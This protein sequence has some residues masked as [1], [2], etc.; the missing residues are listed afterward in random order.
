[1]K[2]EINFSKHRTYLNLTWYQSRGEDKAQAR[3]KEKSL[4]TVGK[5]QKD[6]WISHPSSN[7]LRVKS[8][9]EYYQNGTS[10]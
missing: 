7:S 2:I 10:F 6:Q 5:G 8:S 9:R 4:K 3:V 1:M